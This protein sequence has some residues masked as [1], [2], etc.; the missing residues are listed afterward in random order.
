VRLLY[1]HLSLL[2]SEK[3]IPRDF[4]QLVAGFFS[5]RGK[6]GSAAHFMVKKGE[7]EKAIELTKK[8]GLLFAGDFAEHLGFKEEAKKLWIKYMVIS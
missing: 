7:P 2:S 8:D 3:E 6:Y 4:C 5:K 1:N